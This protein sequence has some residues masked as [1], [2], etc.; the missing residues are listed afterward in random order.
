MDGTKTRGH[1]IVI[2]AT[3]RPN[4]IDQALRRFGRFDREIDIGT[5]WRSAFKF[6][7]FNSYQRCAWRDRPTGDP[8]DSYQEYETEWGCGPAGGGQGDSRVRRSRHGATVHWISA[9]MHPRKNGPFRHW[10]RQN[11]RLDTWSDVS[12]SGTLQI[13][14]GPVQPGQFERN[15]RGSPKRQ[16]GGHWR[17]FTFRLLFML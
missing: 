14:H 10:W 5:S 15:S 12:F 7:I 4:S 1:V 13:R 9:A 6:C 16:M 11:R 8:Q 17:Y 2:G 3:N